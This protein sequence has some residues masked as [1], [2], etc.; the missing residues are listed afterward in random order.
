MLG[1]N[2]GEKF[3]KHHESDGR[4]MFNSLGSVSH[5]RKH[6]GK[7]RQG[8]PGLTL[9]ESLVCDASAI[10]NQSACSRWC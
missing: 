1:K 10:H 4:D 8:Q 9:F 5:A 2:R 3:V 6:V 7:G